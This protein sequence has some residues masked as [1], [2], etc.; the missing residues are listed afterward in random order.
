[1]AEKMNKTTE[2]KIDKTDMM[3]VESQLEDIVKTVMYLSS[4]RM[5]IDENVSYNATVNPDTG[6]LHVDSFTVRFKKT[7]VV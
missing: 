5:D 7:Q 2:I 6:G 3:L 4:I 1:M